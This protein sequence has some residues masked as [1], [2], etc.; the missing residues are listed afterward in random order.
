MQG[1]ET[2]RM[3]CG[4]P[5]K[6]S[7][8]FFAIGVALRH[9]RRQRAMGSSDIRIVRARR[10][11]GLRIPDTLESGGC[12]KFNAFDQSL[13]CFL[14]EKP[15]LQATAMEVAISSFFHA[16]PQQQQRW[17]SASHRKPSYASSIERHRKTTVRFGWRGSGAR[18]ERTG[19]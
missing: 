5:L 16:I 14:V 3:T 17:I 18:I 9:A 11:Q 8:K 13:L 4:S 10:R 15:M 6:R 7:R 19:I 1:H 12:L 2:T